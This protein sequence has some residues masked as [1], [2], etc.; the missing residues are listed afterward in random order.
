[1]RQNRK[2]H[3]HTILPPPTIDQLIQSRAG[4]NGKYLI[5]SATGI[6]TFAYYYFSLKSDQ[7]KY[8]TFLYKLIIFAF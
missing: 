7:G 2:T 5:S 3:P 1:M 4:K 6:Q 8:I